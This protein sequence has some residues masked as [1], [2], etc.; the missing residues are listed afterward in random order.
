MKNLWSGYWRTIFAISTLNNP[1]GMETISENGMKNVVVNNLLNSFGMETTVKFQVC[2]N[3]CKTVEY[4]ETVVVYRIY[5][6]KDFTLANGKSVEKGTRGGWVES[7]ANICQDGVCWIADEAYVYGNARVFGDAI[8]CGEAKVYGNAS[9]CDNARV[10]DKAIVCENA[11]VCDD[12]RVSDMGVVLGNAVVGGK[13]MVYD[14]A[15]VYGDGFVKGNATVCGDASVYGRTRV[16]GMA[17]I[18]GNASVCGKAVVRG[19][20]TICGDAC[21]SG[22]A[23]VWGNVKV[24]ECA[25]VDGYTRLFGH[26]VVSGSDVVIWDSPNWEKQYGLMIRNAMNEQRKIE[27][28]Q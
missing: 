18:C 4:D 10:E 15:S 7:E 23:V 17:L 2:K 6:M 25:V 21:V 5:A 14:S 22:Y 1:M 20:A 26:E 3:E 28:G 9:V 11:S 19:H 13:A 8:V 24:K 16:S 12:A 27:A